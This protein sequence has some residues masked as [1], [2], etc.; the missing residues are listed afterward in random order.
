MPRKVGGSKR[1]AW[2]VLAKSAAGLAAVIFAVAAYSYLTLPDVRTLA[3]TN[4]RTTAFM[5]LR[6]L[7]ARAEGRTPRHHHA[8]LQ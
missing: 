1:S 3:T 8:V 5:E 7:E 2:R 4:P 6:D